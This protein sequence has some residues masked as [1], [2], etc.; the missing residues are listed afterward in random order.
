MTFVGKHPS[1][2]T[3]SMIAPVRGKPEV[4]Y[5]VLRREFEAAFTPRKGRA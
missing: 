4:L 2:G 1:L 3:F 5:L